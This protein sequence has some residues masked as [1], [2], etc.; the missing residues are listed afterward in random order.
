MRVEKYKEKSCSL[1]QRE[2]GKLFVLPSVGLS[3]LPPRSIRKY[4]KNKTDSEEE[5]SLESG[6]IFTDGMT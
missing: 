5:Q 2:V 6:Q 3:V 1:C 4:R